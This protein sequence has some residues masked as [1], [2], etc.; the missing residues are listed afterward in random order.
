[1]EI[2]KANKTDLPQINLLN[3]GEVPHVTSINNE[4]WL[5][6]LEIASNFVVIDHQGEVIGFMVSLREGQDY[7]SINYNFFV[8]HFDEFEYV[9]RI[10]ISKEHQKK[11]LGKKLYKYLFENNKTPI[12]CCEVNVKPA[13]DN[14][15]QFHARLGFSEKSKMIT[16][17]GDKI[18]SLLVRKS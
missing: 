12:T 5:H 18:V 6:F 8:N 11:G 17:G 14:S 15:L 10:V 7:T 13:N 2:R 3:E 9:D 4:D 1:M 16:S